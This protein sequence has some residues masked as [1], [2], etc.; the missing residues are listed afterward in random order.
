[1]TTAVPRSGFGWRVEAIDELDEHFLEAGLVVVGVVPDE[2]DHLAVTVGSLP[3]V[4]ARLVHHSESIPAVVH[5]G[6]AAEQV[7]CS[8][9]GLVKLGSAN[10]V[11]YGVGGDIKRVLVS[12]FLLGPGEAGGDCCRQLGDL[13]AICGGAL[14]ASPRVARRLGFDKLLAR[15]RFLLGKAAFLVLVAAAAR[16]G[17]IASGL[18]HCGQHLRAEEDASLYRDVLTDATFHQL[19]LACDRD[20]ADT[21]RGAGCKRCNGVVHSAHYW[22]KPRGR[23][24]RLGREHDRRFSFCCAVDG[25][26]SRATPPSL[27]FLGPK[28]YIAAIVVLIAILR[29]GATALRMRELTEVIGVDRR[30]VERW[31]TWWRDSFTATPFWQVAR[32]AFM[33]PVDQD[34]LPAALIERFAGDD[35]DRLVALLRF[36]GPL[37]G[38]RMQA[39]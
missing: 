18:G 21:A 3:G 17:I 20:L 32:A 1:M 16:A 38:G 8:R 39:P 23:P 33:P 7:A 24:C 26:R 29:H 10:Q 5:I 2:C 25:C 34:R 36:M 30:T 28:V 31:R 11:H 19:L 22:R 9:L 14:V 6:E 13:Q 12:I 15:D 35:A 37:T 27:R 4:A